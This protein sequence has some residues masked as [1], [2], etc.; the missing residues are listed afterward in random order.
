[1]ANKGGYQ[2]IDLQNKRISTSY[3]NIPG[4]NDLIRGTNKPYLLTG[5]VIEFTEHDDCFVN[6]DIKS[7]YCTINVYGEEIRVDTYDNVYIK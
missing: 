1:M 6:I 5:I 3:Q 4:I 2:I 7:S